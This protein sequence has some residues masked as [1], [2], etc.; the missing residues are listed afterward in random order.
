MSGGAKNYAY[1]MKNGKCVCKIRGFTL[2]VRNSVKLNMS[3]M[4]D[5]IVQ[6]DF[7][8]TVAICN[9]NA[10]KRFNGKLMSKVDVKKYKLVYDKR[11]LKEDMTTVPFGYV[12]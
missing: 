12:H 10:I 8:S 5:L 4:S 2:N 1:E 7:N 3:V 11:V 6:K 9:P